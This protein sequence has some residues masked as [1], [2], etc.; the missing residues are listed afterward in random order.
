MVVSFVRNDAGLVNVVNRVGNKI[1]VRPVDGRIPV[2][3]NQ[4]PFAADLVVWNDLFQL[5][6]ICDLFSGLP[7]CHVRVIL[8]K[9]TEFGESEGATL[10]FPI[11]EVSIKAIPGRHFLEQR[12]LPAL[13]RPIRLGQ[14]PGRRALKQV[15]LLYLRCNLRNKLNGTRASSNDRHSFIGEVVIMIPAG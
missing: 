8:E 3:G 2:V 9:A 13:E 5:G 11:N 12:L 6:G 15:Q 1:H 10:V 7:L 4:N 14:D